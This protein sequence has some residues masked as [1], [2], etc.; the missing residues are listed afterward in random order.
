MRRFVHHL[1]VPHLVKL[2]PE[3]KKKLAV[4]DDYHRLKQARPGKRLNI[5]WLCEFTWCIDH[6]AFYRWKRSYNPYN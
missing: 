1:R 2:E 6:S 4:L 5:R 3:E